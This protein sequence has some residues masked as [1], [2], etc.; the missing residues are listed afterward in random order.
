MWYN[1]P[2]D[3]ALDKEEGA[4]AA[5]AAAVEDED[6]PPSHA[7][8]HSLSSPS[9]VAPPADVCCCCSVGCRKKLRNFC[10]P[11]ASAAHCRPNCRRLLYLDVRHFAQPVRSNMAF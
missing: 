9:E 7:T 3:H 1:S 11:G 6:A 5:A 4:A 8:S 10:W 2:R